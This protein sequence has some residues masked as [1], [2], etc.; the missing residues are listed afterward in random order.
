MK[1]FLI[2]YTLTNGTP[3][4]WHQDI[5]KFISDL[6]NYPELKGKKRRIA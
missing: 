2:R 1:Q 5:A 3:D 4:A 6:N